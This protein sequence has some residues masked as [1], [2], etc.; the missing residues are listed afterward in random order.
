MEKVLVHI[1]QVG[2]DE[3]VILPG[4]ESL[5]HLTG[6]VRREMPKKPWWAAH[7]RTE[8]RLWSK[9][10]QDAISGGRKREVMGQNNR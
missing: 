5:I 8:S 1:M 2:V 10:I 3:E 9:C 4:R 7:L 6:D